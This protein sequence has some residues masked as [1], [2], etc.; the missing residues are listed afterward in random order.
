VPQELGK[1]LIFLQ[2]DLEQRPCDAPF[3]VI[4]RSNDELM[5]WLH[6]RSPGLQWIQVEGLLGEPDAWAFAAQGAS[7][8]PLDVVLSAPGSE[9]ADLYR[10]VDVLAVRDVR[11][12]M[13]ATPG[14]LKAVR[15][16]ASLGL[17]V[18]LLPGHPSAE[19]LQELAEALPFYLHDPMVEAPIEFFHSALAWMRGAET[20]SLWI[21]C[22][23][24]PAI[25]WHNHS[26]G[27]PDLP[28]TARPLAEETSL[29][30]FVKSHLARLIGE[31]AECA[32]CPWQLLCQGYFKWPNP[33]Y[34]CHG[35]KQLFAAL[36]AAADE[37]ERDLA[38]CEEQPA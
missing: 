26:N 22:E 36:R 34:S 4:V 1:P 10:L 38:A 18:R 35:V 5:R 16:A 31:G 2:A 15:L 9:F 33:E 21:I 32:T 30:D 29:H 7:D 17:R 8:I 20:G 13:P 19:A 23:E 25:F 6:D 28:R 12:S 14:F 37:I 3:V 24:D 27:R 11:V